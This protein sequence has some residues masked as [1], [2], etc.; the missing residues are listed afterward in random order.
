[1]YRYLFI[2][3]FDYISSEIKRKGGNLDR[4]FRLENSTSV[5]KKKLVKAATFSLRVNLPCVIGL[6]QVQKVTSY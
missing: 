4:L 1:M 3:L 6:F 5:H 2:T